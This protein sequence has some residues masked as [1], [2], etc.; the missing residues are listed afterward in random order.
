MDLK[1]ANRKAVK[2]VQKFGSGGRQGT[3]TVAQEVSADLWKESSVP[4][5]QRKRGSR[6]CRWFHVNRAQ[7]RMIRGDIKK[8]GLVLSPWGGMGRRL[9]ETTVWEQ[10]N[11]VGQKGPIKRRTGFSLWENSK[12]CTVVNRLLSRKSRNTG[13]S[14]RE[15]GR[16]KL[17][18]MKLQ[19]AL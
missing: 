4:T 17:C 8:K 14:C 13:P 6:K 15:G 12:S 3:P 5:S 18:L 7:E 1:K 10:E 9:V 2:R 11:L 19:G 16:K